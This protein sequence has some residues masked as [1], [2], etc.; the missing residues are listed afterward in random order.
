MKIAFVGLGN[1]GAPMARN[2]LRA[3]HEVTVYNRTQEKAEQLASDG[4]RLAASA[5]EAVAG[6]EAAISMLADDTAVRGT[7]FG[8]D[9]FIQKLPVRAIHISSSTISVEL[10]KHLAE[11]HSRFGQGYIAA[12]V[13][14]RPDAAQASKLWIIAAGPEQ[15]IERCRPLFDALGRGLSVVGREPWQAN[16]VKIAANFSL[17]SLLETLGEAAAL[18]RKTGISVHQFNEVVNNLFQS[19]IYAGYGKLIAD[20]K[21]EPA[22]FRLKLGLKDVGLALAAAGAEAVPMPLASLLRDH[23]LEAVARGYGEQDWSAVA[24]VAAG[25]AGL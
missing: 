2:L 13:L 4:A 6:C 17:A 3:G 11:Y 1:M 19:P 8:H 15:L 20:E 21:Y 9:G 23:Y 12:P 22:G 25:N 14:G 16:M 10:S 7:V 5:C 24:R 18:M